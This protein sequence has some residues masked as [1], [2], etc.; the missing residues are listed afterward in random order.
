VLSIKVKPNIVWHVSSFDEM[1]RVV[2]NWQFFSD[3]LTKPSFRLGPFC[4]ETN[5]TPPITAKES[6]ALSAKEKMKPKKS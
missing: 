2:R 3:K 4:S 1:I 5:A 6:A